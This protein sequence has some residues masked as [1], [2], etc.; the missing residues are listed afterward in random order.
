M[1]SGF[2]MGVVQS[3]A[4]CLLHEKKKSH[5]NFIL[6][7]CYVVYIIFVYNKH[8]FPFNVECLK[9]I[10][11]LIDLMHLHAARRAG[12]GPLHIGR[13][14]RPF[15]ISREKNSVRSQNV[16]SCRKGRILCDATK[17]FNSFS[18]GFHCEIFWIIFWVKRNLN[19][20]L[21]EDSVDLVQS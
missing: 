13:I 7:G 21:T 19:S 15:G 17:L 4:E 3:A 14:I 6:L 8:F 12:T 18:V 20:C 11:F 16:S 1:I 5:W 9:Y 2:S 10:F